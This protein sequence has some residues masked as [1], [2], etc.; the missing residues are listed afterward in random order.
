[1][2]KKLFGNTSGIRKTQIRIIETLYN[3]RTPPDYIIDPELVHLLVKLSYEIR[4]Q[5]GLLIDR[6]GKVIYVIVGEAHQIVIPVTSGYT[7]L[8]G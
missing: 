2:K 1:M 5:I 6:N 4:R 3:F 7:A 8:P